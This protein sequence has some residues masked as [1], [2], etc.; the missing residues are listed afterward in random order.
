MLFRKKNKLQLEFNR[1]LLEQLETYKEEWIRQKRIIDKSVEPSDKVLYDLKIAEC[2][3][4]YLLK[5]AK[6]RNVYVTN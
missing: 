5:E 2:K 4:L 6:V 1:S 3:Y